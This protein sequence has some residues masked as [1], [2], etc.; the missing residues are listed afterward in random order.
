V[1]AS[2]K[3]LARHQNP[4]GSWH[5][6]QRCEVCPSRGS[7][8]HDP[9]LTGLA[10]LSFA[11]AGYTHL[12]RDVYDGRDFGDAVRR[13]I[14]WITNNQDVEGAIG[15]RD[16]KKFMYNHAIDTLALCELY[17]LTGSMLFKDAAQKAVDFLLAAQNPGKGWRYHSRS[18]E[19]D[20]SVTGWAVMALVSARSAGL[21]IPRSSIDGALALMRELTDENG[22]TGYSWR[23]TSKVVIEGAN[24]TFD[25][26][27]SMT[28]I[29]LMSARFLK[30][31]ARLDAAL[32]ARDPPAWS[33]DELDFYYWYCGTL[34][35]VGTPHAAEW[36]K[37]LRAALVSRQNTHSTGCLAG[38]WDPVDRWSSE[39]GRVYATAINAMSLEVYYRY[40][41]A[42]GR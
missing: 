41:N 38:S 31:G 13:A 42:F 15:P 27:E 36:Q 26:H 20:A 32:V 7:S 28:A 24:D 33:A 6:R 21:D 11:G 29:A 34:A 30:D 19:N 16:A 3:W 1:L 14:Q 37:R 23:G 22:R 17:G 8:E 25:H 10:L 39:G 12:S 35:L 4:D 18:G 40:A 5:A 9:G 2:L